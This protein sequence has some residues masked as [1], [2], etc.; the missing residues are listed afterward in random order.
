MDTPVMSFEDID[1]G[2]FFLFTHQKA[3]LENIPNSPKNKWA[4]EMGKI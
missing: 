4:Y 2:D 3:K 1:A